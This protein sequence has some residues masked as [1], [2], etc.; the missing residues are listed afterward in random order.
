M[1]NKQLVRNIATF[2]N[3]Y[4][5]NEHIVA[6]IQ[7]FLGKFISVRFAYYTLNSDGYL[8]EILFSVVENIY[9]KKD[10]DD[11]VTEVNNKLKKYLS[12]D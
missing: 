6:A 7:H 12:N 9:T 3:N 4:A 10:Y 8:G 5:N 11:Y 2:H 1:I